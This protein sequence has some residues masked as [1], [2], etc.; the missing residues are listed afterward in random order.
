MTATEFTS[1]LNAFHKQDKL[2]LASV[3]MSTISKLSL[4]LSKKLLQSL[5]GCSNPDMFGENVYDLLD[6]SANSD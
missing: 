2:D 6:A 3:F 1:T 4:E 5:W